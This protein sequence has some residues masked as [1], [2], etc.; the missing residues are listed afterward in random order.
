MQP[1]LG[2]LDRYLTLWIFAA[3]GIGVLLGI[4][5]PQIEQWNESMSVGTTNIPLAIGLILMMY[6]PLA[7]VNYSLLGTVVK[8][9]Q[10]IKLSLIMNWIV[11]PILMFVLAI[12]FLGDHPGYMVGVILIGLARCVAMVLV[13]NDIGGGNKEYGAALVAL[14]SAFQVV[15][16]SFMAW[17]FISVL[18]PV[19]GY[20]GMMVDISMIDIAHSV[21]IYLGIPFLAGF[22]SRKILVSMKGEQWYNEVFIPRISPI[23]LIA[24][25]ATI[26]LMFSLKGEMIVELP[27]D[28][29]LIAVPLTI[30]F[31]VMF[32]ISFF[33]GKR[34]G[35][36]YDKNASIAFTATGNNFELAI[37]VAISVFG[38]NSDQAF[39]G[40]IGPHIEVP[41]LI[42]LVNVALKMK[43]K[44]YPQTVTTES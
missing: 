26:V 15:S 29:L 20:E 1:K 30:Y 13:W 18:P 21:L 32:F 28:V 25:L 37:A 42:Y 34:M 40:V 44:Y 33:I 38:I 43:D 31:T 16:Y 3:M 22:L 8:D 41:V 7:K 19:F 6:P 14:N 11:G 39:A 2:F 24:L 4:L 17:L 27:M 9:K 12:T 10:A 5:F 35:I 23:T 36:A